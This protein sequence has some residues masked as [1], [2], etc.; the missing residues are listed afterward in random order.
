MVDMGERYQDLVKIPAQP[1]SRLLSM[2]GVKLKTKLDAPVIAPVADV[3]EELDKKGAV[4]DILLL[5][6]VA[7]P[8]RERVWWSCLAARDLPEISDAEIMSPVLIA[9]EAWVF[10]PGHQSL[11]AVQI[12][13]ENADIED[14]SV[15]CATAALYADGYLGP[16]ELANYEAPP[17]GAE[18][19]V[20]VMITM[21]LA[22]Q[23]DETDAHGQVLID[24]AL[25]IARGG[26]GKNIGPVAAVE[27]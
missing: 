10:D 21:S 16:G 7:L 17:G 12:A 27:E 3:L 1:A 13:I 18:T 26:N 15:Y 4:I 19:M 5:L 24:R 14:D 2:A 20:F 25:D 8:P 9:T 23:D 6:S 11:K 22:E